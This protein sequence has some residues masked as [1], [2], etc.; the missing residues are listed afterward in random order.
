MDSQ[1]R[2]QL[3]L[4]AFDA[5]VAGVSVYY[6]EALLEITRR[7]SESGSLSKADIGAL[8]A[9]K[10]LN[11]STRWMAN[12]M[13]TPD[14]F[15]RATTQHVRGVAHSSQ[16]K[17]AEAAGEARSALAV[18]PGFNRGDAL[19]SAVI[20]ALAPD[21]MAVY[22]KRAQRGLERLGLSLTS[23]PGRY[24]RYLE[25]IDKLMD[26]TASHGR[27]LTSRQVDLALFTLGG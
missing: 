2:A 10:R 25:L 6:D 19:A 15:V 17:T 11:A 24:Q 7:A 3:L 8:V 13:S 20:F 26:E 9:W 22:D 14:D 23:A 21:R 12:F 4:E 27:H 18:L 5:Y 16:L 1:P